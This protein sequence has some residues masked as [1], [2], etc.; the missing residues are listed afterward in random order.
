[1]TQVELSPAGISFY[2]EGEMLESSLQPDFE[3]LM[4]DGSPL[5]D[6]SAA[7]T[8]VSL[9]DDGSQRIQVKLLFDQPLDLAQ[10]D[11][12]TVNGQQIWSETN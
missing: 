11:R 12:L 3:I 6:Y 7:S 10:V 4:K 5:R 9:E 8:M 1:M 2:G